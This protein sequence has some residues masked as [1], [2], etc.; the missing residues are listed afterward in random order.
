MS[1][2]Q[3]LSSQPPSR[4][5]I[6]SV[7]LIALVTVLSR[8]LQ[9]VTHPGL[10]GLATEYVYSAEQH[11]IAQA[12]DRPKRV[13]IVG[14]GASGSAAAWFLRRA[15][16]I[17]E[18]RLGVEGGSILGEIVVFER[19]SYVGGRTLAFLPTVLRGVLT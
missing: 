1:L 14:A 18:Q 3:R 10:S 7:L 16:R 9:H 12:Q 11:V 19:E 15:G 2:R 4:V 13:A 6:A 8:P 5:A 17:V